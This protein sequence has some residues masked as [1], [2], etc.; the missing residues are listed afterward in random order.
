MYDIVIVGGGLAGLSVALQLAPKYE[1]IIVLEKYGTL[2]GRALTQYKPIQY[3]IGAGRVHKSHHRVTALVKKYKLHTYPISTESN[4]EDGPNEFTKMF[5]PIV[6]QLKQ[7]PNTILRTH[8][9]RELL[10]P[11]LYPLLEQYPYRAELELLRADIALPTFAP[12]AEMG[13]TKPDD[14]YGVQ[15]GYSK[16]AEHLADE[17]RAAGV[18]IKTHFK[19]LDIKRIKDELFEITGKDKSP[20]QARKVIIATCRCSLSNFQ[21]LKGLPLLKQLQT[22]PLCRIYAV[23]P[24]GP[25]GP[26]FATLPKTVTADPLRYI[27]PI[28]PKTG[29]IM[30]SYT[31]GKDAE[32]WRHMDDDQTKERI[33]KEVRRQFPNLAIPEPTYLKKHFWPAGC[34]YWTAGEYDLKEAQKAAM[35][36][37]PN[38]YIVGES[39]S[40]H[41][42]WMESALETVELLLASPDA[43]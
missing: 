29:L 36:P 26:W 3:E 38:L 35:F 23:Y 42:A 2:G 31:D 1:H 37:S 9:I 11:A 13:T 16:I 39:V 17:V 30:I 4:Y 8:T 27:I 32:L 14:F 40:K 10:P 25:T 41:Q 18:Q 33:Q 21:V 20:I 34:T 24:V 6:Q 7:L 43:P 12:T 19:V 28:N 15:E 22:S 5:Y